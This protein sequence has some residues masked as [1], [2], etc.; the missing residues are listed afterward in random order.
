MFANVARRNN[1]NVPWNLT[2]S[3]LVSW[4]ARLPATTSAPWHTPPPHWPACLHS[5]RLMSCSIINRFSVL[6][7]FVCIA[8]VYRPSP[9]P[10][11]ADFD[12]NDSV[13]RTTASCSLCPSIQPGFFFFPFIRDLPFFALH[14]AL[15]YLLQLSFWLV[16]S[17]FALFFRLLLIHLGFLVVHFDWWPL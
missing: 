5:V 10:D 4:F 6:R 15:F 16:H 14:C 13:V 3:Q 11:R 1:N 8:L 2:L 7:R 17:S 9:R 12:Y